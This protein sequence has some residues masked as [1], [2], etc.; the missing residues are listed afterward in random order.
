MENISK[1]KKD[2]KEIL[3]NQ[4]ALI[5]Q[6]SESNRDKLPELTHALCEA[7][8]EYIKANLTIL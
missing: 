8:A 2:I 4:M 3:L 5:K 6:E 7:A 1:D